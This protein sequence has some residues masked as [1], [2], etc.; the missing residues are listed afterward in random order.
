VPSPLYGVATATTNN[1]PISVR[2]T[3]YAINRL[4]VIGNATW[5]VGDHAISFGGWFE[6]NK[7]NQSRRFYGLDLASPRSSLD[8]MTSPFATQW[9]YAFKTKTSQGYLED[10]WSVTDALKVNF[11]FKALRVEATAATI[12]GAPV[13]AGTITSENS[14]LPQVGVSYRFNED[15]EVFAGYTENM[16]AFGA[17]RHG[18]FTLRWQPGDLRPDHR[19][20]QT[21]QR[22]GPDP[23]AG[24]LQD[25]GSRLALQRRPCPGC[26]GG[27]LRRVREPPAGQ[28]HR[29]RHCRQSDSPVQCRR[30]DVQGL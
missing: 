19:Q 5:A 4:G 6:E 3:E 16:R 12:Q 27:L 30:R 9:E 26:R 15:H 20:D 1:A 10:V 22:Q 2:T 28:F 11:G 8:F 14:F 21:R 25:P 18:R 29:R 17:A 13:L 24:N 23:S 7:F